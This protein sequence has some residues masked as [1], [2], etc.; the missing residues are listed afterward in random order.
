MKAWPNIASVLQSLKCC[1]D[2]NSRSTNA[3]NT[4]LHFKLSTH[5]IESIHVKWD[6][7]PK[8]SIFP[9]F[10]A[11]C[12]EMLM[13]NFPLA[14]MFFLFICR[15]CNILNILSA[16]P[17]NIAEAWCFASCFTCFL[18]SSLFY[19]FATDCLFGFRYCFSIT[20]SNYGNENIVFFP[21]S[22][23]S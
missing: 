23:F 20:R 18:N 6:F 7:F 21:I 22:T 15:C 11:P 9:F 1:G 8:H 14:S 12:Q 3:R 4:R 2:A 17:M 13:S 19:S 10:C 16:I 5:L